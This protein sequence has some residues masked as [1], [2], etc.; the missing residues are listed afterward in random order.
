MGR[1]YHGDIDGK[2]WFAVQP[3]TS[4]D[5]FGVKYSEPDYVEYNFFEDDLAD[6]QKELAKIEAGENFT[7]AKN[8]F[9]KHDCWSKDMLTEAGLNEKDVKDYADYELGKKIEKSIIE[10]DQCCFSAEL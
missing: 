7:K 2:F 5:R 6:V 1:Y 3:S 4:A 9:D 8:F 10:T